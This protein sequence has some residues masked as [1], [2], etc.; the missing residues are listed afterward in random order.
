M[1]QEKQKI[2]SSNQ[3]LEQKNH[4][5]NQ[6]KTVLETI[7]GLED[8]KKVIDQDYNQKNE[9][10]VEA[11]KDIQRSDEEIMRIESEIAEKEGYLLKFHELKQY[12]IWLSEFF[13]PAIKLIESNV[14]ANI[15]SE[16]NSLFRKWLGH[17]LETGDITVRVD[18]NFTP[19]I[20][21]NGYEMD[22]NSLSGGEKTSVA[23]AYRLALNVMVKKV[24]EAMQSNLLI[25]DEPTDGFSRE[26]LFRLRD[27]LKELSCEQV[28]FVSHE[29][30][31]EGFVDKIYRITKESGESKIIA[32]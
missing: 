11:R 16:F 9:K 20:E 3:L 2:K 28:I 18:D 24:C 27:I 23:L 14:L 1:F 19:I 5:Y 31:L 26:Q 10:F 8:Q 30:E 13:I 4:V 25:L 32:S 29:S 7:T 22:V 12:Q 15:N 21:Q 17:L 6:E